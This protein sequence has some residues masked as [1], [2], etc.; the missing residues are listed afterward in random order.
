VEIRHKIVMAK[1][2][3]PQNIQLLKNKNLSL[4]TRKNFAI[5]SRSG[6]LVGHNPFI[7]NIMEE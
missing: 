3:F 7:T 4:M 1:R 2:A 5:R 6:K